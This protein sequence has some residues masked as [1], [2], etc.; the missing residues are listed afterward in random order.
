ML[1][2][3][4]NPTIYAVVHAED[5]EHNG[6]MAKVIEYEE[7]RGFCLAIEVDEKTNRKNHW[8]K[9]SELFFYWNFGHSPENVAYYIKNGKLKDVP[10]SIDILYDILHKIQGMEYDIEQIK[11]HFKGY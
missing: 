7:V 4:P 11:K 5:S 1:N 6:E 3:L 10:L 9:S 2:R 8:Y